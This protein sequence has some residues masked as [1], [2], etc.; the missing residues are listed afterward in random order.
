VFGRLAGLAAAAFAAKTPAAAIDSTQVGQAERDIL[1]PFD[2][3]DGENPYAVHRDLQKVMQ[4]LVGIF[5]TE[6]DLTTAIGELDKLKQRPA[7]VRVEGSRLFNPG[8]HL[9]RDL[10]S[11][12][13][14]SEAVTHSAL[15]RKESRGAHS[16]IDYP[17]LD[18]KVWGKQNNVIS[19]S[20]D[21]S[22]KL[23]QVPVK[24]M[25]EDLKQILAEEK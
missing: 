9:A 5:R 16:R 6:E 21:G 10:Q 2:R 4:S 12:L 13:T 24:E 11:M 1:V 8:W 7:R 15:A 17:N 23:R 14:V 25:P 20:S 18:D 19:R 22:M 3:G